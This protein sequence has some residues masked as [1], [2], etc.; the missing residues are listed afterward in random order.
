[1]EPQHQHPPITEPK[2]NYPLGN[3][4]V[5][6]W[7]SAFTP[8][9]FRRIRASSTIRLGAGIFGA[10]VYKLFEYDLL[11]R[12]PTNQPQDA[13]RVITRLFVLTEGLGRDSWPSGPGG[14]HIQANYNLQYISRSQTLTRCLI[15]SRL[16]SVQPLH[17]P[18]PPHQRSPTR[19]HNA[20]GPTLP[21][22]QR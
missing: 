9:L 20:L 4:Q 11:R 16:L 2:N 6:I 22:P 19:I 14:M 17:P 10:E 3:E 13:R 8:A 12:C 5:I 1:M 15:D 7:G 21:R 18:S